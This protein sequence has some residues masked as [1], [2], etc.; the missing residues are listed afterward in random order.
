MALSM[1]HVSR[2]PSARMSRTLPAKRASQIAATKPSVKDT[3][4]RAV[5]TSASAEEART[6][7]SSSRF[8]ASAASSRARVAPSS[9]VSIADIT[10]PFLRHYR[11]TRLAQSSGGW[12]ALAALG[13]LRGEA[14]AGRA[15][16]AGHTR[17]AP[18]QTALGLDGGPGAERHLHTAC[19]CRLDQHPGNRRSPQGALHLGPYFTVSARGPREGLR[20]DR[21][22][23]RPRSGG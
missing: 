10:S 8:Q 3:I 16:K 17:P 21:V 6:P 2:S 5:C 11:V 23:L 22:I 15:A 4:R 20:T 19:S 13:V 9:R 18:T 7:A 1:S 14:G 12:H